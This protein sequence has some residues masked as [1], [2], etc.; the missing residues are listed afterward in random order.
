MENRIAANDNEYVQ[1]GLLEDTMELKELQLNNSEKMVEMT[2]KSD[3]I[4][5]RPSPFQYQMCHNR[6]CVISII[7]QD[8]LNIR[9][10]DCCC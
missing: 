5:D 7:L 4:S 3:T 10:T 1:N 6:G 9:M 2:E 8:C